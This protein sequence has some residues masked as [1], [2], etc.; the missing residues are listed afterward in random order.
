MRAFISERIVADVR[1]KTRRRKNA[2]VRER[3]E[4]FPHGLKAAAFCSIY[5]TT[6]VAPLQNSRG[7]NS[8][9]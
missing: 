7:V 2:C 8:V 4:T 5:G 1:G 6:E 9:A 3:E